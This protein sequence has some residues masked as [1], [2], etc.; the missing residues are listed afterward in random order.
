[1]AFVLAGTGDMKAV[2]RVGGPLNKVESMALVAPPPSWGLRRPRFGVP[3]L[4]LDKFN[5]S[6][7]SLRFSALDGVSSNESLAVRGNIF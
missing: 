6:A 1:M 4:S 2:D 7:M 5:L 3:K